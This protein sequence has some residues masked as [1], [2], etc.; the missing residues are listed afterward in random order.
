M[1]KGK[2]WLFFGDQ[3]FVYDFLYQVEWLNYLQDGTLTKMDVAFSRDQAQKIYV[4]HRL[5]EHAQEVYEWLQQGA[6]IYVCGDEKAMAKDVHEALLQIIE[7]QGNISR[8]EAVETLVQYQQ[9]KRYQR[10]VY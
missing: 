2:S 9:Q 4:Q 6:V 1:Q 5:L 8:E 3:C 10:D 7:Q